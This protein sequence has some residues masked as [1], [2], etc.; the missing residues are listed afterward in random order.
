MKHLKALAL[1]AIIALAAVPAFGA[2]K[3]AK[4]VV[5]YVTSWSRDIPD[6]SLMTHINYAFGAVPEDFRGV[7]I[8][9]E[10]RLR[11][12]AALK[13]ENPH[14]RVL[15]SV[16]GWGSGRFSEMAA[17]D[18][19]RA[20][21]ARACRK[22]CDDYNLDGIDIDWEY[23]TQSGAG[24][25]SSPQDT[26]HFTL[27]MRDLRKALGLYPFGIKDIVTGGD[28]PIVWTNRDYRMIY[29]NM[30][31]GDESFIDATQNLL[32]TNAFRWV[33]SRDPKGNPFDK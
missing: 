13:K 20:L 14:L 1:C 28:F 30:G 17:S 15:L 27:L 33:V 23:P 11:A 7:S 26:E 4:V 31:H 5:A 18:E 25:S 24:I 6:P 9:N 22:A 8:A 2:G 19:Y 16:G 21:F 3:A 29:L 12:I 32:F 10:G